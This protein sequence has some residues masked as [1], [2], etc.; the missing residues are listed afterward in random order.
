[1]RKQIIHRDPSKVK[2][3]GRCHLPGTSV[4]YAANNL[5]TSLL[6]IGLNTKQPCAV[7]A[8]FRLKS[9]LQTNFLSIG[10]VD[11][12]R[13]YGHAR[14]LTPGVREM[15]EEITKPLEHYDRLALEYMD[16]YLADFFGRV[17]NAVNQKNVYEVTARVAQS[18]IALR[19]VEGLVYP[20]VRH[21]GGINFA[22]KPEVFEEKFEIEKFQL[23]TP[24]NSYGYGL[25]DYFEHASGSNL[26]ERGNFMWRGDPR[27]RARSTWPLS[28]DE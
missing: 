21:Q 1:M 22:I 2:T 27:F 24:V 12:C 17:P 4:F 23:T 5:D 20:S 18:F 13:R 3:V 8:I 9:G 16:A 10:E 6:E 15:I 26:D 28:A 19:E 14:L 11:H 25:A 7:S